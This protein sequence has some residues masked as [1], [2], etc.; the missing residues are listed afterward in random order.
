MAYTFLSASFT[1]TY[2]APFSLTHFAVHSAWPSLAPFTPQA[3]SEMYPVQ[4]PSPAT[5]I[6]A[7]KRI[8]ATP[9][10]NR[11]FMFFSPCIHCHIFETVS[12]TQSQQNAT[13]SR[14]KEHWSLVARCYLL[15]PRM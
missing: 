14:D 1:N 5:A 8:A 10:A 3:L 12:C 4:E 13:A 6:A 15:R 2:F 7:V 11:D 9:T